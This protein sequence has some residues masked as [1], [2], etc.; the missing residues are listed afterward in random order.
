MAPKNNFG[1][2]ACDIFYGPGYTLLSDHKKHSP[3]SLRYPESTLPVYL[4][5][6]V[7]IF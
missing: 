2:W 4:C 7:A 3:R 1:L 5:F 6:K